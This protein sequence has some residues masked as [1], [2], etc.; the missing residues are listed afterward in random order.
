MS[1]MLAERDAAAKVMQVELLKEGKLVTQGY[2]WF[3]ENFRENV[4]KR[5]Y[6][7][8]VEGNKKWRKIK[9]KLKVDK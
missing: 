2:V 1:G 6:K 7:G 4:R 3:S 5:K 9:N 8:K